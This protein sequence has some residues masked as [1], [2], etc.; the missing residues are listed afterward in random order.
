MLIG[1]NWNLINMFFAECSTCS[2]FSS[3]C[4][5]GWKRWVCQEF[6]PQQWSFQTLHGFKISWKNHTTAN[7]A[8][9][10]DT[11]L[12]IICYM[13]QIYSV[14]LYKYIIW[15]SV[16]ILLYIYIY[17]CYVYIYIYICYDIYIYIYIFAMIHISIYIHIYYSIYIHRII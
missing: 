7:L 1:D 2:T 9:N 8:T 13:L 12:Y 11:T 10:Q 16:Y 3:T 6:L 14:Y 15:R 17:I 5:F 4:S